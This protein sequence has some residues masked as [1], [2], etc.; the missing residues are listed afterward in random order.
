MNLVN[1][2]LFPL[3]RNRSSLST[4]LKQILA[5]IGPPCI[6]LH[7]QYHNQRR[8]GMHTICPPR[9]PFA[10]Q[11]ASEADQICLYLFG[12]RHL[13]IHLTKT[14]IATD[15]RTELDILYVRNILNFNIGALGISVKEKR[16]TC[17]IFS[18]YI[19]RL[20]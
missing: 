13:L 3:R 8:E 9:L 20:I 19:W 5:Q 18:S 4:H 12:N 10:L 14:K 7:L 16:A 6:G 2:Q 17:L 15:Y 11:Q 1:P